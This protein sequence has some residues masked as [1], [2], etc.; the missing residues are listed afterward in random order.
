MAVTEKVSVTLGR[1]ELKHA[2]VLAS[3]TG[4]SLSSF[5]SEALRARIEAQARKEA[6][7]A[8][9]RSFEPEDLPTERE[10]T[11]LLN[12]WKSPPSKRRSAGAA[13]ARRAR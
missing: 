3:R 12:L 13:R 9:V 2:K 11:S 7:L 10:T 6:A 8:L 4:V 1:E 5:I